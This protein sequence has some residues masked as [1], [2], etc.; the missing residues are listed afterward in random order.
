MGNNI[1][2]GYSKI[3][4]FTLLKQEKNCTLNRIMET[5]FV[6]SDLKWERRN[7]FFF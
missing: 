6:Y 1:L 2:L 4:A 5:I 7:L 3:C